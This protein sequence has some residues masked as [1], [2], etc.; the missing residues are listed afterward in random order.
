VAR[1][2]EATQRV[3]WKLITAPEGVAAGLARLDPV[4]RAHADGLVIG[5]QR[6]SAAER[7]DIYANMYF[8]RLRDALQEDFAAV[9]A[10]VGQAN[11]HNLIT[12]YL[13]AHPP[14]H[15]SLRYAGERLPS[16]LSGHALSNRWPWL[17]DLSRLEWAIV[18]A[19]DAP[20]AAVLEPDTLAALPPERWPVLRFEL[21]PSLRLL[22][23]PWA[24]HQVWA[25]AHEGE[26]PGE[27]LC[28]KTLLRVWRQDFRVYHRP[29]R[30]A[31]HAALTAMAAGAPFSEVCEQI[32]QIVGEAEG[33]EYTS[34]LLRQWLSDSMLSGFDLSR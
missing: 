15:F 3:L 20:D 25:R 18:D 9:R 10:V 11:F 6:L 7:L 8:F 23:V 21:T 16:F 22:D 19:F 30:A 1:S 14:S 12:D 17:A 34:M 2:L 28:E 27:P 29:I 31:E 32:T 13:I 24:V 5:D 4:E 33:A 26:A